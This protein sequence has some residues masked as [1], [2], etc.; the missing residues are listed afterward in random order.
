MPMHGY[1]A[2]SV[3]IAIISDEPFHGKRDFI[4]NV[5]RMFFL[6]ISD[7]C[8]VILK[9]IQLNVGFVSYLSCFVLFC[10]V[11]LSMLGF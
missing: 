11:F 3:C 1:P 7:G 2:T 5:S 4:C 10:F 8:A 9:I 6:S